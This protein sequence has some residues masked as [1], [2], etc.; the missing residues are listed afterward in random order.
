MTVLEPYASDRELAV[1]VFGVLIAVYGIERLVSMESR[2]PRLA[3]VAILA[4]L[5]LHF[6]FFQYDYFGDY[7]GR[8]ASWY[9]WNHPAALETIIAN[10]TD[11]TPRP[12][13]LSSGVEKNIAAFWR[14]ALIKKQ[15]LDLIGHTTYFDSRTLDPGAIP[16]GALIFATVDDKPLLERLGTGEL[17]EVFRAPEPADDSVFFVLEKQGG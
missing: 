3:T 11:S 14:L 10:Q 2:W 15:R 7:H 9:E 8:S 13:Y 5:P 16:P 4:A 1:M 17:R 6:L 12:V